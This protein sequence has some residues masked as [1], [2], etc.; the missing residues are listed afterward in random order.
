MHETPETFRPKICSRQRLL[1]LP[2][3]TSACDPWYM[4]L[5]RSGN[6]DI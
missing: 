5:T 4:E 6:L 2:S 1:L 3:W